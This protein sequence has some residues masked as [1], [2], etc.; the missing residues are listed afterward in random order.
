M[1]LEPGLTGKMEII[2]QE[3]DTARASGDLTLPAVLSTPRLIGC[4]EITAHRAI[5]PFLAE[6]QTSVGSVVTIT[7]LTA[8]PLGMRAHFQAELLEVSGR[9]L[10]FRLEAWDEVEKIA[11][12]EHVRFIID[13]ARFDARLAEKSYKE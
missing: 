10:R 12:G 3:S 7:H 6:G 9:R 2:V 11:E 13:R 5:L 4:L 8:T 1:S